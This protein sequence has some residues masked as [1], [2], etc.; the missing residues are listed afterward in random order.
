MES[1]S[2]SFQTYQKMPPSRPCRH[3][4]RKNARV[5]ATERE[6]VW[7]SLDDVAELENPHSVSQYGFAFPGEKSS[8]RFH[9]R[10]V[11]FRLRYSRMSNAERH[12]ASRSSDVG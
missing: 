11:D 10:R 8:Y 5:S 3:R 6:R 7:S 12:D 4:P 1:R 2:G 9:F